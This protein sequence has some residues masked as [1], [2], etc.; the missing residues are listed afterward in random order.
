VIDNQQQKDILLRPGEKV[1]WTA[2]EG[3]KLTVGNA[4][5]ITLTLNGKKLP[6]LGKSG[7]VLRN[8]QLPTASG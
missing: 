8:I 3:F 1:E 4:G 5:G 2:K 7:Q 6:P